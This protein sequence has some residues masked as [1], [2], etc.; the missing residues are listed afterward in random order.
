M[1]KHT[2]SIIWFHNL[3]CGGL[4]RFEGA[5]PATD[6]YMYIVNSTAIDKESYLEINGTAGEIL[7]LGDTAG[8]SDSC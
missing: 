1:Y 7:H 5:Q 3:S 2:I 4:R 8:T 6:I